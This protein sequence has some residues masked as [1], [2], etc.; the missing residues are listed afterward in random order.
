[1]LFE[2]LESWMVDVAFGRDSHDRLG[3]HKK[4]V[5]VS[6]DPQVFNND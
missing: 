6:L 3:S 1:M 2:E 5:G 4:S